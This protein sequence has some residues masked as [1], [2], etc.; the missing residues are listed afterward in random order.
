M[1]TWAVLTAVYFVCQPF[2][3]LCCV[4]KELADV[5]LHIQGSSTID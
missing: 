1:S 3:P 2:L 4:N 5:I